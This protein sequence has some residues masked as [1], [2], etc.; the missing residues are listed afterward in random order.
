MTI[1]ERPPDTTRL[2][3][4]LT[5]WDGLPEL[6]RRG[7]GPAPEGK[8]R[9]WE[10]V[11]RMKAPHGVSPEVFWLVQKMA[12]LSMKR[13][14]P[15]FLD[16]DGKAFW[17][18][19]PDPLLEY[20]H[21]LNRR[22]GGTLKT[23]EPLT[24]ET[25]QRFIQTSIMEEA[26]TSSQLEGAA[27]TRRVAK[28]M[29]RTGRRPQTVGEQMIANNYQTML[30]IRER[31]AEPLSISLIEDVH[32][33]LTD[34]VTAE[35]VSYREPGD[36]I[37]V[38]DNITNTLLHLPPAAEELPERLQAL[39]DFVNAPEHS[40]FMHPVVKAIILHFWLAYIHPFQDGNGRTA[41]ALFYWFL[42]KQ[43]FWIAEY[44]S[45]SRILRKAPARYGKSF[46]YTETDENDLT[47]F[48]LS[49]MNVLVRSV[50]DLFAYIA[51][52]TEEIRLVSEQ[53]SPDSGFNHRQR[54]L[55]SHALRHPRTVYT[56]ESHRRSHR[57]TY[58]TARTDL[59]ALE[60]GELLVKHR[61]GRA[62]RFTPVDGLAARLEAR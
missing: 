19:L 5:S 43:G 37:G 4:Q 41:R 62:F 23:P 42:L 57:V 59:L 30:H 10:T 8:Y 39:C 13:D 20:Q 25:G 32:L 45:I 21:V 9:H 53:L 11:R 27:T 36:G 26:I 15:T 12:R 60:R 61:Q 52:K 28:E 48:I 34:G 24:R 35:P 17:Y 56:I 14:I 2:F 6:L 18:T 50:E 22:I 55:L 46:L 58:Q 49:Q 51:A 16:R 33:A 38:Y 54:A 31:T 29:I 47:Y 7:I 1:P 44:I 40:H 3:S